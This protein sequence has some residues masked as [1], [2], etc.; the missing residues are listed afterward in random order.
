[1]KEEIVKKPEKRALGRGLSALLAD[2]NATEGTPSPAAPK[3][4]EASLPVDRIRP[5]PDQPRRDFGET[6]LAELA[7][8]IREKG[9]LQPIIVRPD[10][11][12]DGHFQIVAGERRWRA[13]QR[14]Q[15]HEIPALV[16]PLSDNEVLEFGIIE[17]IQ[18]AD[19][20]PVEEAMGYRQLMDRFGHTQEKLSEAMGKSRS[21]IANL[22][23]LLNLP[24]DVLRWLREGKLSAGHARA[25]IP[26]PDPSAL[27][28]E[29]IRKGL[30]VRETER[31]A[32]AAANP[33]PERPKKP[34][35]LEKDADT[36][37]LES[38]LTAQIGLKV[39]IAHKSEAG[40][41]EVK[42]AY[43]NLEELD[44]LCQLLSRA[45]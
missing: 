41:G 27:A 24:E 6:E 30:S 15:I 11:E 4:A 38:D 9:V 8:S 28:A 37:L 1:M 18:R 39:S 5:N 13:A 21:H 22:L 3:S 42:I 35:G 29:V 7:A 44:G 43:R 23:R 25:L 33:V 2:V 14:A 40:G 26:C 32:K 19:L 45:D 20:N 17:N 34:A 10:P 16:R 12:K 36:R 31:L